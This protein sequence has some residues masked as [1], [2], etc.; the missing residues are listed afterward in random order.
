MPTDIQPDGEGNVHPGGHGM[1]VA[2]SLRDLPAQW[3]PSRLQ[4]LREGAIGPNTSKVWRHGEGAF[5]AA[6]VAPHLLLQPDRD[7]HGTVAPAKIMPLPDYERAIAATRP[8]W[9]IDES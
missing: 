6:P 9:V 1:S 4:H 5:V 7:D 2:P 3:V 8:D